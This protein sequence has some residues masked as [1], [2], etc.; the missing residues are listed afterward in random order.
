MSGSCV[1]YKGAVIGN[2]C[3]FVADK[4]GVHVGQV[5]KNAETLPMA[6]SFVGDEVTKFLRKHSLTIH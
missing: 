3:S 1:L 5:D 2:N 6:V 4:I